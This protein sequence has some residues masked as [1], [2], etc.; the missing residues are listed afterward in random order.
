[1]FRNTKFLLFFLLFLICLSSF[2]S[3]SAVFSVSSSVY[4]V[5]VKGEIDPGWQHFLERSLEEAA[6]ADAAAVVLE[7]IR[8]GYVDTAQ[9]AETLR[10]FKSYICLC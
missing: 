7:L 1:M 3:Y 6:E 9:S 2:L 5:P 4:I 10:F 8:R